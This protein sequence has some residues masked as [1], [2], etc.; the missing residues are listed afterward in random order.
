MI[1]PVEL[2]EMLNRALHHPLLRESFTVYAITP[3]TEK[4]ITVSDPDMDLER[5]VGEYVNDAQC[6]EEMQVVKKDRR[7]PRLP[8][9][10]LRSN[11]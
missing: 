8:G 5:F 2:K 11:L 10:H 4:G 3:H 1:P 7:E 9:I 6:I